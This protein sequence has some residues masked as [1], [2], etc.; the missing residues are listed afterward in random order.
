[1]NPQAFIFIG[2]SGCGKGTQAELLE[3]KL[4]Q[5]EPK[6]EILFIQ[7]GKYFRE[8]IQGQSFTQKASHELYVTGK[9]QPEFLTVH[10]WVEPLI[11]DFDGTQ[12]VIFD[13]TPRKEHEA[14]VLNSCFGFYGLGKPWVIHID[15]TPEESTRRLLLRQRADDNA[16]EIKKRLAWYETDVVPTIAYY[17][18]NIDY[19]YLKL[20]GDRSVESIHADIVKLVGLE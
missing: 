12:H 5:R 2:R 3:Q 14:G 4:K 7:T 17:A 20:N 13:G 16:E 15:I 18:N 10:V 1:M 9:L 19:H 11:A 6:R 8:F